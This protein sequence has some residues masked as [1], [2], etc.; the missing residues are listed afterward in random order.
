MNFQELIDQLLANSW[1]AGILIAALFAFRGVLRRFLDARVIYWFWV[2]VAVRLLLP[3]DVPVSVT[4]ARYLPPAPWTSAM[5]FDTAPSV[6]AS[7]PVVPN[8]VAPPA[9]AS[10]REILLNEKTLAMVWAAGAATVLLTYFWASLSF[11]RQLSR[12]GRRAGKRT[13]QAVSDCSRTMGLKPIPVFEMDALSGPALFG[14]WRPRLLFPLG[15]AD[16]LSDEELRLVVLHELGHLKRRDLLLQ[17]LLV[18]SQAVHWFN[19]LVW[20]AG[21]LAR[22]DRE[23]ACDE[24]V[25]AH[26]SHSGSHAYAKTLLRVLGLSRP[27][28]SMLPAVGILETKNQIKQRIIMITK[29]QSTNARRI[30]LGAASILAVSAGLLMVNAAESGSNASTPAAASSGAPKGW[31]QNGSDPKASKAYEVGIDSTQPYKKPVSVYVKSLGPKTS[32]DK[33]KFGG[34]MQMCRAESFRGKRLKFTG[35]VKTLDVAGTANLWFRVDG[36]NGK[37][38]A[39]DN[40]SDRPIKGTTDWKEYSVV[41]DVPETATALAYGIFVSGSGAGTAWLNDVQLIEVGSGVKSTNMEDANTY[42]LNKV[43]DAPQ[44]L[45]FS[46]G[47]TSDA[48][49]D[50]SKSR[51]T[52]EMTSKSEVLARVNE[53]AITVDQVNSVAGKRENEIRQKFTGEE[54]ERQIAEARKQ[55]LSDLI[56]RQLLLQDFRSHGYSVTDQPVDYLIDETIRTE[57]SGNRASFLTSLEKQGYTLDAYKEIL[58]DQIRVQAM[59]QSIEKDTQDVQQREQ[60]LNEWLASARKKAAITMY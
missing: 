22:E 5:D 21:R 3:F 53:V 37:I 12:S 51:K 59:R 54:R 55:A 11:R 23:L 10:L 47:K 29:Y 35:Y 52:T 17:G 45:D 8:S 32:E 15:L 1:R 48:G 44:N 40:M 42:P 27:G 58:R 60:K 30:M 19:P 57:F 36:E 9:A 38:L 31:V 56:N 28:R 18:V 14:V 7:A 2:I 13:E 26:T 20:L 4:A 41:L 46:S 33:Y 50:N 16:Q 39:F 34:M 25:M 49:L 43:P 6:S 24:F